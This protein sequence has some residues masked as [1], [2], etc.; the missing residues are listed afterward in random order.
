MILTLAELE[1]NTLIFEAQTKS[2]Q[3]GMDEKA[4]QLAIEFSKNGVE[5]DIIAKSLGISL[6]KLN[7]YLDSEKS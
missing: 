1:R 2:Y 3:K 4:K 5:K 7:E 6:E